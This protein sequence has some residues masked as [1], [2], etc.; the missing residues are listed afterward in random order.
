MKKWSALLSLLFGAFVIRL[1]ALNQ[2]LWLD[3]ATTARVVQ[4]YDYLQILTQ[5]SPNDFHP[6][7]YYLFMKF[8]TNIFGYTE[9]VLRMPSVLASLATGLFVYQTVVRSIKSVRSVKSIALWA[10]AFFLFNPLVIYYSQEARM[11]ALVTLLVTLIFWSVTKLQ[12]TGHK[13]K[14]YEIFLTNVFIVLALGTYYGTV[15]FIAALYGYLLFK[16]EFK[17]FLYLLPGTLIAGVVLYPVFLTQLKNSGEVLQAIPNWS[18]TLG[19]ANLKNLLLIPIKFTS[20]RISWEPKIV[21]YAV[22]GIW[23]VF[24][25]IISLRNIVNKKYLIL[26]TL[27]LLPVLFGF[28]VSFYKPLLQ[29]FRFIYVIPFLSI[30]LALG[31]NKKWQRAVLVSGFMVFSLIYTYIPSFHRE[32]WKSLAASLPSDS[33]CALP[34][35]FD[36]LK[37]YRP[38]LIINDA[39]ACATGNAD[40]VFVPY[41][42]DIYGFDYTKYFEEKKYFLTKKVSFRGVSYEIWQK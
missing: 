25:S 28:F 17:T 10:A 14:G 42:A 41:V 37:Y 19:K 1:I 3:E 36:P 23:T 30:L 13:L 27:Y 32:D 12:V 40:I 31:A 20:G 2:S 22:A 8:W 6:P 34:S 29:Y 7:L 38:S 35:S 4:Q 33:V 11:Y 9:V 15:F 26:Y 16:R 5:F 18:A 39:R 24:V 21:Y